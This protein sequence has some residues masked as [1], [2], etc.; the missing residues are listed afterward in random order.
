MV[1]ERLDPSFSWS[2][3]SAE[4]REFVH[5]V[6]SHRYSIVAATV[7]CSSS[8]ELHGS[9]V[10]HMP[11]RIYLVNVHTW[12]GERG[13]PTIATK[14][15]DNGPEV[16]PRAALFL[17]DTQTLGDTHLPR[18]PSRGAVSSLAMH[19]PPALPMPRMEVGDGELMRSKKGHMVHEFMLSLIHI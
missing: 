13:G 16:N 17:V 1:S 3:P 10:A 4:S 11:E 18:Q 5:C 15:T 14:L 19:Q 2:A 8:H 9:P 12:C 7:L 6:G